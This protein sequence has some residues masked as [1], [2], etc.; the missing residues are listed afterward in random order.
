MKL[1]ENEILSNYNYLKKLEQ[2][3]PLK[4]AEIEANLWKHI[5]LKL[6][7]KFEN[8]NFPSDEELNEILSFDYA[9][10]IK[11]EVSLPSKNE[12]LIFCLGRDRRIF[13]SEKNDRFFFYVEPKNFAKKNLD[14]FFE[15]KKEL[16]GWRINGFHTT[17]YK[18]TKNNEKLKTLFS[19]HDEKFYNLLNSDTLEALSE[20]IL[21]LLVEEEIAKIKNLPL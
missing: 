4:K 8:I 10:V 1:S 2:V 14:S 18:D 15:L 13:K 7:E 12:S 16:H 5:Y 17:I 3:L 11:F 21:N 20:I 19:F 9:D 6:K